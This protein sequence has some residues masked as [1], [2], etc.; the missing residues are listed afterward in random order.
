MSDTT[1]R[2]WFRFH[3]LTAVLILVASGGMGWL[4]VHERRFKMQVVGY[5]G[6]HPEYI[7]MRGWPVLI[8]TETIE[9]DGSEHRSAWWAEPSVRGWV[10]IDLFC[11]LGILFAV[12]F[13]SESI[14]RRRFARKPPA[15]P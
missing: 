9:K 12:A 4:E 10:V 14:F 2:G 11:V 7:I 1:R 15:P 8:G 5:D 6:T 3:L 13:V